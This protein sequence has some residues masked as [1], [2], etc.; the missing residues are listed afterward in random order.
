MDEL[1]Q[2][3]AAT[4][5]ALA[6]LV[7]EADD[8]RLDA[9]AAG[10]WS[11]RTILAHFR[12]DEVLCMRAAVTRILA[13]DSPALHFIEGDDWEPR[14]N[15]L[16]DRKEWLLADFALQRQA[17]L[18]ILRLVRPG[19]LAR[20]GFRDG[21]EF[22]LEHLIGAWVRHDREHVAQLERALGETLE[23]VRARRARM[24]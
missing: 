17:S 12:D 19:D 24:E 10:E 21:R 7:A 22:T 23:D 8:E 3:L 4:P 15:R 14:R 11:A 13:E 6:H 2:Q 20:N 5:A 9:A 18:G 16:R 1:V